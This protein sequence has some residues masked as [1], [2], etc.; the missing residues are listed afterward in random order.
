LNYR[1]TLNP[2]HL[3]AISVGHGD[4]L[5]YNSYSTNKTFYNFSDTEVYVDGGAFTGDTI[6]K[7]L[8]A[9]G[10]KFE[11]IYSFEPS[12]R[13]NTLIRER[14]SAI[15]TNFIYEPRNRIDLIEK[16]LWS[17]STTLKF[18]H[19]GS[20]EQGG[21]IVSPQSAHFIESGMVE[22]IYK[23]DDDSSEVNNFDLLPVVSIDDATNLSATFIKL[24]IE[25]SELKALEGSIKTIKKNRPKCAISIYHKPND[26]IEIIS[27]MI[28]TGVGY[29][30]DLRQHNHFCPDAMVLYCH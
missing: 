15:H 9:T 24:E 27:F 29:R 8:I 20:I 4:G 28:N 18:N 30:L 21:G 11:H 23:L 7:F 13:N 22:H 26:F 3:E 10:G 12:S 14:L 5:G 16:G 25:G 1:L 6:E 17:H 2:S 19:N